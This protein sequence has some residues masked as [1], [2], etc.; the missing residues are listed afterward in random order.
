[1][2]NEQGGLP[3]PKEIV[4]TI[5][6]MHKNGVVGV[7]LSETW[8]RVDVPDSGG[9]FRMALV[10]SVTKIIYQDGRTGGYDG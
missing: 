8:E 6:S 9:L 3:I 1:M 5:M 10:D 4:D 2:N 7:K